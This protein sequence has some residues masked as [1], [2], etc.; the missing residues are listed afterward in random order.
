MPPLHDTDDQ[1]FPREPAEYTGERTP[2]AAEIDITQDLVRRALE[3]DFPELPIHSAA[4]LGEGW[5]SWAYL[6]NEE[7]VFRFPKRKD[8]ETN[9]GKEME[10][11]P[12]LGRRLPVRVPQFS[13]TATSRAHFPFAYAGY[14]KMSGTFSWDLEE[15]SLRHQGIAQ[16]L[17]SI[18]SCLHDITLTDARSWGCREQRLS[19]GECDRQRVAEA[20]SKVPAWP[21][22]QP[23]ADRLKSYFASIDE[24]TL[25]NAER[26]TLTHSDLLPD[27]LLIADDFASVCG[28]IDW[29]EAQIGDPALDFAGLYYWRGRAFVDR[30]LEHY[31]GPVD[32]G[33]VDRARFIAL[34]VGIGDVHY[35]LEEGLAPY[36]NVGITCL[37]HCL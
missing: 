25:G 35:G 5:N 30:V 11:L 24:S 10:L 34:E 23:F 22:K 27:H 28:I 8:V 12:H 9:L 19:F 32:A 1:R 36:F 14:R 6:V 31:T 15:E 26:L 20:L 17:A 7:W 18:L 16:S 2:W 4:S 37:R 13:Y 29:G 21:E 3:A 33:L